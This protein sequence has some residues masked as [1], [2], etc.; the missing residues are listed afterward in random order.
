MARAE[1]S[2]P[3][4]LTP[5]AVQSVEAYLGLQLIQAPGQIAAR[6]EPGDPGAQTF[7]G[8]GAGATARQADLPLGRDAAH[9]HGD[10]TT[11]KR[12]IHR[13]P[14]DVRAGTKSL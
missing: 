12:L 2:T 5:L 3:A 4:V 6:I 13:G 10:A 7:E 11:Q 14:R 9:Q 1:A 8:F